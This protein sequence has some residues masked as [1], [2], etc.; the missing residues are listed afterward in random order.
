MFL[1]RYVRKAMS[2]NFF[3]P[4]HIK[5]RRTSTDTSV[6]KH[7]LIKCWRNSQKTMETYFSQYMY[8]ALFNSPCS[9]NLPETR[10]CKLYWHQPSTICSLV[11]LIRSIRWPIHYPSLFLGLYLG[12]EIHQGFLYYSRT[13]GKKSED[14]LDLAEVDSVTL[15]YHLAFWEAKLQCRC[16]SLLLQMSKWSLLGITKWLFSRSYSAFPR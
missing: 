1:L 15:L 8:C 14:V 16:S 13:Y 11:L 3:K 2:W 6:L 12:K 5:K 4:V 10:H 9:F 7:C